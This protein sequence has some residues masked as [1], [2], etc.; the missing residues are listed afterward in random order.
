[1]HLVTTR[2]GVIV[3]P[4]HEHTENCISAASLGF[5]AVIMATPWTPIECATRLHA[6]MQEA[7]NTTAVFGQ[8]FFEL[9]VKALPLPPLASSP[10]DS[11]HRKKTNASDRSKQGARFL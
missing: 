9:C 6:A 2:T 3:C 5:M 8:F 11:Q 1:M 10:Q 4:N 7:V